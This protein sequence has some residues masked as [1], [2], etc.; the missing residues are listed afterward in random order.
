MFPLRTED[1]LIDFTAGAVV[2]TVNDQLRPIQERYLGQTFGQYSDEAGLAIAST[3]GYKFGG[4]I[5]PMVKKVSKELFRIAVINAGSAVGSNSVRSLI[6]GATIVSG[7]Q[8]VGFQQT[9]F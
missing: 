9:V 7:K 3:I 5:H 2:G 6:G 4:K 1:L 8:P